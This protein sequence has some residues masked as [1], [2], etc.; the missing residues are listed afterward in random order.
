MY[1]LSEVQRIQSTYDSPINIVDGLSHSQKDV[2]K[3]IEYYSNSR[4]LSGNETDFGDKPFYNINKFRVNVAVRATDIDT[5]DIQVEAEEPQYFITSMILGK[6][7]QN[8]MKDV[9]FAE[10]LNEMTE[11]RPKY[12]GLL[13]KKREEKDNLYLDAVEWRNVITDQADIENGAIIEKHYMS[14]IDLWKKRGA[15]DGLEENWQEVI[16]LR[17][18]ADQDTTEATE[19]KIPVLE[20]EAELPE[21]CINEDGDPEK[22]TLQLHYIAGDE[23]GYQYVLYSEEIKETRYK[24]LSWHKIPGRGL[25]VGVVEDGFEAQTWVNDTIIKQKEINELASRVI[26]QTDDDTVENNIL[27]DLDNGSI[28]KLNQGT[29]FGQVNTLPNSIPALNEFINL[30]NQQYERVSSTFNAITGETMP[31]G[32]PFRQAAILNQEATS[33]FDYKREQMGIFLTEVFTDWVIPY[34]LKKVNREHILSE[35]YTDEERKLIDREFTKYNSAKWAKEKALSGKVVST[36]E[37]EEARQTYETII[38]EGKDKRFVKV[39]DGYFKDIKY[40]VNVITTGEQKNKA[41]TFESLNNILVTVASNP[42]IL[43]NDG[44]YRIFA[45]IVE[46]AGIGISPE[47]LRDSI[48]DQPEQSPEQQVQGN[49]ASIPVMSANADDNGNS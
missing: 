27:T 29:Q 17:N 3:R 41:V 7:V 12:G 4:Y 15:W 8:W 44:L 1:L 21:T 43:Q 36:E 30:W 2:L 9:N 5:K 31:S 14:V 33:L 22:Y 26:Y 38:Q 42:Q 40:K 6:E 24:Y 39:P 20:V 37:F 16:D 19:D 11:V 48:Q 35:T 28:I 34:L 23:E 46:L 32:T 49:P 47:E 18:R 13:L 45:R 25:G 10:T